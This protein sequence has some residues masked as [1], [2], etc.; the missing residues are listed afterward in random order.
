MNWSPRVRILWENSRSMVETANCDLKSMSHTQNGGVAVKE[1]SQPQTI[2][3]SFPG[4]WSDLGTSYLLWR[5]SGSD[6][7]HF[8]AKV[9]KKLFHFHSPFPLWL[10]GNIEALE[11]RGMAERSPWGRKPHLSTRKPLQTNPWI[12][13][14]LLL[15][16]G[17]YDFLNYLLLK[18]AY[19]KGSEG[20]LD[21]WGEG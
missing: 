11:S 3:S 15:W 17:H 18:L 5:V 8:Q 4:S 7:C 16:L 19:N 13:H 12:R 20:R 2:F 9:L 14:R 1:T 21:W 10:A 6:P